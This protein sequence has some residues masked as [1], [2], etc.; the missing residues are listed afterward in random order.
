MNDL[1]YYNATGD[2]QNGVFDIPHNGWNLRVIA[3]VG[4]GWEHVSV[5]AS[6]RR[7][8]MRCPSWNE[9][10][11]IKRLFFAPN[12]TAMQLHVPEAEHVNKHPYVL[13]LWRPTDVEIPRPPG[14]M[15][16]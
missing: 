8:E 15:V 5:H 12:E 13:H 2:H 10:E 3:S 16:A 1:R 14:W 6:N 7:G 11:F 9:M 4:E